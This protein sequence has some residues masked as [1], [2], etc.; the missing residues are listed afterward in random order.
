MKKITTEFN[1]FTYSSKNYMLVVGTVNTLD[2][3]E[4]IKNSVSWTLSFWILGLAMIKKV[5][6]K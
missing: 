4:Y 1:K 3:E 2:I 5:V 6:K